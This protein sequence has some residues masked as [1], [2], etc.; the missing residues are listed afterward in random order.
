M[1]YSFT[2]LTQEQLDSA[3]LAEEGIYNFE[4]IKSTKKTSKSGNPMAELQITIWDKN[5]KNHSLFDY[6][7]FSNIPLNIRK[8]K[9]FCDTTGLVEEYKKGNLPEELQ[10]KCG[11]VSIGIQGNQPNPKGGVYPSKNVVLDYVLNDPN[12]LSSSADITDEPFKD[13]DEIPF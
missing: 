4:V 9:N 11:K 13:D 12:S 8:V 2:P 5:G 6:L 3:G 10:G 7:V 1:S